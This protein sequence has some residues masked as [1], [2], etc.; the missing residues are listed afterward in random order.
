MSSSPRYY[1]YDKTWK[2]YRVTRTINGKRISYGTYA[3]EKEAQEVVCELNKIGWD[4]KELPL[5]LGRLGI[6]SKIK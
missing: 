5:I 2:R 4:K 1:N 3:T 6:E